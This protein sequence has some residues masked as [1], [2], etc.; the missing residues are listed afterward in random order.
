VAVVVLKSPADFIGS[1]LGGSRTKNK[2]ILKASEGKVLI[3]DEAYMLCPGSGDAR[4]APDPYKTAVI[5]T[6]V[7]EVQSTP[8]DDRCVLLLGGKDQM[9]ELLENSNPELAQCFPL[10]HALEFEDF[11]EQ[12]LAAEA[13]AVRATAV[14]T[15]PSAREADAA[16]ALAESPRESQKPQRDAGISDGI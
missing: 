5:D 11:N 16:A 6:I 4:D 3:I 12:E 14:S 15:L 10:D 8:A 13:P 7:A 2:A 1:V 9:R